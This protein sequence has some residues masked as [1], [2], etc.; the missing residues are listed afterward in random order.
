MKY[1]TVRSDVVVCGGGCAGLGAAISAAR[2]GLQVL[3]LERAPF[4]G[5]IVSNVGLQYFDGIADANTDQ[6]VLRG[7]PLELM[8]R[9]GVCGA[10]ARSLH[11]V[12]PRH[13]HFGHGSISIPNIER[14]KLVTDRMLRELAPRLSVLYHS[15]VCGVEMSSSGDR[16]NRVIVANKD[17]LSAVEATMV[18][19]ATGDADVAVFAGESVEKTTPLMPMTLHFRI[20]EVE[21]SPTLRQRVKAVTL[22]A[23][24]A[25]AL[26]CFYGPNFSF[27]FGPREINVHAVRVPGDASEAD[28]LTVAEQQGREDAWTMFEWWKR[29]IPEFRDAYFLTSGPYIGVRETR[30]LVGK[31]ILDDDDILG[32]RFTDDGVVTGSWYLDVHPNRVTIGGA[33]EQK[34]Y[35]PGPYDIGLGTFLPRGVS[36]LAVVGRCHSATKTAASSSRVTATCMAMGQAIGVAAGVA[37]RLGV[38]LG[39]LEGRKVREVL[40]KR[41][42]APFR[43]DEDDSRCSVGVATPA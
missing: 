27:S 40:E 10:D 24:E 13:A 12:D 8:E 25:G 38:D 17:G 41:G 20:A 11:D 22:R 16:V 29:E 39:E 4:A 42:L 37:R 23:H 2:E 33:N 9:L 3:M 5:G 43:P 34:P 32:N 15:V 19:D 18:I 35:W 14:F 6:I 28:S 36:N 30:R 7:L 31:T 21:S 1:R 26:A